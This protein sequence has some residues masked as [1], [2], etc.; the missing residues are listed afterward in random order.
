M[1]RWCNCAWPCSKN[2]F[3]P[4]PR[5]SHPSFKGRARVSSG[6]GHKGIP[7]Y[8]QTKLFEYFFLFLSLSL[9]TKVTLVG[10]EELLGWSVENAISRWDQG[11]VCSTVKNRA[12]NRVPQR[13]F[14]RQWTGEFV[15]IYVLPFEIY[16]RECRCRLRLLQSCFVDYYGNEWDARVFFFI[17]KIFAH[18]FL[19]LIY[20]A[21]IFVSCV[22]FFSLS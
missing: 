14:E 9:G 1:V 5:R 7:L 18:K 8:F 4:S 16:S 17:K 22:R 2:I 11:N 13:F 21:L 6:T 19:F 3:A 10:E 12:A 20:I 15:W